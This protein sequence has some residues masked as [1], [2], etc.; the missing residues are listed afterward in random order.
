[1]EQLHLHGQF[2]GFRSD[3][4]FDGIF[5]KNMVISMV[6]YRKTMGEYGNI[7]ENMGNKYGNIWENAASKNKHLTNWMLLR[8]L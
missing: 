6:K 3:G 7:W 5:G 8:D 1:M 4:D 2:L